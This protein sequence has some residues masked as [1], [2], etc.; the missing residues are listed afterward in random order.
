MQSDGENEPSNNSNVKPSSKYKFDFEQ[1]TWG[2]QIVKCEMS[3]NAMEKI[4]QERDDI[5]K[6][7][8]R[9]DAISREK[10]RQENIMMSLIR[11]K[12]EL[13]EKLKCS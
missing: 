6:D 10:T 8:K 5:I 3:K 7:L 11:L 4:E 1:Y 13:E 12:G 2:Q 9:L